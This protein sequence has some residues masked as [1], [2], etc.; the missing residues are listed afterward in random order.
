M[1]G[2]GGVGEG[3]KR[4]EGKGEG[5]G[6]KGRGGRKETKELANVEYV[7]DGAGVQTISERIVSKNKLCITPAYQLKKNPLACYLIIISQDRYVILS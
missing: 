5:K 7:C 6:G 4:R 3:R 2:K 1:L